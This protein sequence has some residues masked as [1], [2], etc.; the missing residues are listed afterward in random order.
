M[1]IAS[2]HDYKAEVFGKPFF[3][4]SQGV[5]IRLFTDEVNRPAADN[6]AYNHPEDFGLYEIGAFDELTGR[7]TSVEPVKLLVQGGQ[8]KVD[9]E[10]ISKV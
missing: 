3:V 8:V 10:K 2:I 5:A 1:V 6:T 4:P 9:E 7:I